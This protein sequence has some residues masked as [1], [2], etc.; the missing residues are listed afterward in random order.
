M[1]RHTPSFPS[2]LEGEGARR[3]DE[4]FLSQSGK[5]WASAEPLTRL[6]LRAIHPLPQGERVGS[7]V[8]A[9]T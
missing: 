6:A 4:G 7:V 2:P 8:G 5:A 9:R 3:A 1:V